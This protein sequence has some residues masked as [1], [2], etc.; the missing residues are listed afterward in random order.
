MFDKE[1]FGVI[2]TKEMKEV[3]DLGCNFDFRSIADIL[4]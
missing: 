4:K 3:L 1:G 2:S